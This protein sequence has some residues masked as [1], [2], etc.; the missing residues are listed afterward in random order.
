MKRSSPYTEC[1]I[2]I[3]VDELSFKLAT[4]PFAPASCEQ[5]GPTF[6]THMWE[7]YL[8]SDA[9]AVDEKS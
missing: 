2:L 3:F 6:N 7:A 1:R 5:Y 8:E 4:Y 9:A